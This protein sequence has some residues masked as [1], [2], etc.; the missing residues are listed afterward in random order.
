MISMTGFGRAELLTEQYHVRVEIK[1]ANNKFL[2]LS[3]NVPSALA[4]LEP[5]IRRVV[6]ESMSRGRL[7]LSI[8][9][10]EFDEGLQIAVDRGTLANYLAA[11]E[12][13]REAARLDEPVRLEH[14][15]ALDGLFRSERSV[16][17]DRVWAVVEPVLRDAVS[18]C[19]AAR[20]TEGRGLATDIAEQMK[21]VERAWQQ[22]DEQKFEIDLQVRR[23]L[24]ERFR[25]VVGDETQE[26]RMLAEVAVQLTRFSIHEE[27]VRLKAHL[28]R[29]FESLE[30]D[31]PVG[32]KLDFVCQ[33]MHREINT[34]GSKS[35][36]LSVSEQVVEAK[37]ALDN[38]REQLRNVE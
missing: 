34:I 33:E 27:I 38:V 29:F 21:R 20:A 13:V 6:G 24:A 16:D 11:I 15:L 14:L 22:I 3:L 23:N 12:E 19:A 35:I 9:Y 2:D 30:R 17:T 5:A 26:N 10:R 8:R 7:D 25:E 37:E 31:E 32:K 36:V 1:S 28:D 18:E 4:A